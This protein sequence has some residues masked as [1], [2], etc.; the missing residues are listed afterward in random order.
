VNWHLPKGYVSRQEPDYHEDHPS[1]SSDIVHQP[2]AYEVVRYLL[3]ETGRGTVI[4]IGCGSG[5]KLRDL[6]A[7]RAIGVDFGA[8][9]DFCRTNF[10][11]RCEWVE[12]DL[13]SPSARLIANQAGAD[14]IVICADVVE[15]LPDPTQLLRVLEDCYRRGAIV[16]TTTPDR[17]R[18][19]GRDHDGPPPNAA[20]V[21]EWELSEYARVLADVGLGLTFAGFTTNNTEAR[22][23]KTIL[24]IS[25]PDVACHAHARNPSRPLAI[26][27]AY[28]EADILD[29]VIADWL[30]QGCDVHLIDNW[31]TDSSWEIA[32]RWAATQPARISIERFPEAPGSTYEWIPILNRKADIAARYPG[33]WIVHA[34]ADEI[35]RSPF[36]GINLAD[37]FD[38]VAQTGANRIDFRVIN[39]RPIAASEAPAGSIQSSLRWFDFGTRS[40]HMLQSKA[41]LQGATRVDLASTGGHEARFEGARGFRYKFLLKHYPMRSEEHARR[42][43]EQERHG[44]RSSF[45]YDVLKF[46][47]QYDA[48]AASG[49]QFESKVDLVEWSDEDFWK[50]YGLLI[51]TDLLS[52]RVQRGWMVGGR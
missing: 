29:E 46:H 47:T 11:D 24:T 21:R 48:L 22:E 18:V 37:G 33:R 32:R 45:E 2:E 9:I 41:W 25:D 31:S 42:K 39:F 28:N 26:I 51:M 3:G 34:D 6:P 36:P 50:D 8:N 23:L 49:L 35:R 13:S 40:G 19:R 7:R 10:P 30:E 4:D 44:R 12:A 1:D 38:L 14:A 16:I 17:V 52:S 5:R 43:I 20:H 27:A 15:H